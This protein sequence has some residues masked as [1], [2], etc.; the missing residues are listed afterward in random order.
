MLNLKSNKNS[1]SILDSSKILNNHWMVW[2]SVGLQTFKGPNKTKRYLFILYAIVLNFCITFFF[3]L[4]FSIN[5]LETRTLLEICEN[6]TITVTD[7]NASIKFL[8]VFLV[9]NKLLTFANILKILDQKS[10]SK[11]ELKILKD[12]LK[13]SHKYFQLFVITFIFGI[14]LSFLMVCFTRER[15]L[16][17]PEW[18]PFDWKKS[19]KN[20]TIATT[21]QLIGL[22][23]QAWQ[24][25]G[26]DSYPPAC[27]IILS[28]H[29]KS[30]AYR[31]E[32][33]GSDPT[34]SKKHNHKVLI[35]CI[36]DHKIILHLTQTIQDIISITCV[37]QLIS[38]GVVQCTVAVYILYA[39]NLT[40]I[41]IAIV[42]FFAV[43]SEI[44]VLCYFGNNLIIESEKLEK[45]IINCNWIDQSKDFRKD[46]IFF[47]QKSQ[48]QNVIL[49]GS[50]VPVTYATFLTV[51]KSA[52]SLFTLLGKI[53]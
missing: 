33:I 53:K 27:L 16:M 44:F 32:K 8:N 48:K 29:I 9:R 5:L 47:L 20:F 4:T 18:F 35:E 14:T 37:S 46:F 6:L 39:N 42:F 50:Y 23:V 30:L 24:N 3:P 25:A 51:L 43:T 40:R 2:K 41:A 19:S 13:L 17:F 34:K 11:Y 7:I 26:S 28:A 31:I 45:A 1:T 38:S 49:A 10:K 22:I 21:Y 36:Q 15:V 12:A 52:Y